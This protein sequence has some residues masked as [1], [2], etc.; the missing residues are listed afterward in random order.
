MYNTKFTCTY[1]NCDDSHASD[2]M[3]KIEFL[4][5]F[6]F[7]D[8]MNSENEINQMIDDIYEKICQHDGFKKCLTLAAAKFMSD[9]LNV[10]LMVLF[11]YDFLYLSHPC[12]A[13]FLESGSIS[14]NKI[15]QLT[16]KL[17]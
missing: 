1:N 9:E 10:G 4:H 12:V 7:E 8:F 5:V 13:E 6:G 14:K 11:S 17:K 3:Y 16:M 2:L 15:E